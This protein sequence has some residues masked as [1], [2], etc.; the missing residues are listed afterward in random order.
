MKLRYITCSDPREDIPVQSMI[1][2]ATQYPK[3]EFGVQA[4]VGP[5]SPKASRN[6][7]F[8]QIVNMSENM[9][10]AP[11]LALHVNYKWC[12]IM[13]SGCVPCE[14]K[15]WLNRY[16][17]YTKK[18]VI[19]R[20]QLN[21]GD[22]AN[23]FEANKIADLIKQFPDHEFIF[24]WNESVAQRIETLKN[25][26]AKFSLLFDGSYGAGISPSNWSKP[27]YPDVPN[28]YAGGLGPDNIEENLDKINKILPSDYTTWV[29]AEG[30]LRDRFTTRSFTLE[31]AE[32]YVIN[33]IKWQNQKSR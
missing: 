31:L 10:S 24:P 26:G 14:L 6:V 2:F 21:I 1:N 32:K 13:C 30:R 12:D 9:K 17:R 27:V 7:W 33:A 15:Q 16:N 8:N 18:P 22:N 5:M 20:I 28:G 4:H 29:D 25:T 23:W 3:I 11:N 19:K